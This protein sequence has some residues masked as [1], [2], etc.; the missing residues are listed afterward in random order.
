MTKTR[1]CAECRYSHA[2]KVP[3]LGRNGS[4]SE[5]M[6]C[7]RYPPQVIVSSWVEWQNARMDD[8]GQTTISEYPEC[9][10]FPCGEFKRLEKPA[11]I[12]TD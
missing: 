9:P 10:D 1:T 11:F 3:G 6:V 8:I 4:E 5:R 2:M 12:E 7:T